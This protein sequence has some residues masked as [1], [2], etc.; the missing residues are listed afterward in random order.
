MLSKLIP[1]HGTPVEE[2]MVR[3]KRLMQELLKLYRQDP[4]RNKITASAVHNKLQEFDGE[5]GERGKC[6]LQW[7]FVLEVHYFMFAWH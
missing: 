5:D 1:A 6:L 3:G 4:K 2:K 7:I